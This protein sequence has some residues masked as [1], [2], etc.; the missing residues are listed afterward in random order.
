MSDLLQRLAARTLGDGPRVAPLVPSRFE[1]GPAGLGATAAPA[2]AEAAPSAPWPASTDRPPDAGRAAPG[3]PAARRARAG[4]P[5][6]PP[7]AL[8]APA[9]PAPPAVEIT[10]GRIVVRA[11]ETPPASPAPRP[12]RRRPAIGLDTYLASRDREAR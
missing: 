10:I 5:A 12:E 6:A 8:A 7:T 1:P 11:A 2:A 9:P 3:G 4:G